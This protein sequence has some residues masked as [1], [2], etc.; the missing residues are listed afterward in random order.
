MPCDMRNTIK[1][2]DQLDNK[3]K[4]T[5]VAKTSKKPIRSSLP[6]IPEDNRN[7]IMT[8]AVGSIIFAIITVI[9]LLYGFQYFN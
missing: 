7:N 2:L 5:N 8:I 4:T 3:L 6:I 9:C 1:L